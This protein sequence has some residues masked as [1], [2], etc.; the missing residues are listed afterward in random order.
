M[1]WAIGVLGPGFDADPARHG[2]AVALARIMVPYVLL[3]CA[4]AV[5]GAMLNG[6]GRFASLEAMSLVLNACF[7]G[8]LVL[9]GPMLSTPGLVA[10][11]ASVGVALVLRLRGRGAHRRRPKGPRSRTDAAI[12]PMNGAAPPRAQ[13]RPV[14]APWRS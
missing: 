7:I 6:L 1:P 8:G 4:A 2:L 3:A 14:R 10:L 11:G 13:S 12:P 5:L 9:L